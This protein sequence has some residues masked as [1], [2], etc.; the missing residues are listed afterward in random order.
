MT[1]NYSY[2]TDPGQEF[3]LEQAREQVTREQRYFERLSQDPQFMNTLAGYANTFPT[4]SA[5]VS[6]A[7]SQ[8]GVPASDP[9]AA[10]LINAELQTRDTLGPVDK[11]GGG[12]W[13]AVAGTWD[14]AVDNNVKGAVRWGF[15]AWDAA[16][17]MLAGGAP[18][19]A[20][21]VAQ[22]ENI[23]YGEAWKQQDPYFFEAVGSL[24]TPGE[25]VNLGSGWMPNSDVAPDVQQNVNQGMEQLERDTRDLPANERMVKRLEGS[26]GIWTNAV[27]DSLE[28][29]AM[30]KPLTHMNY[31]ETD[32]VIFNIDSWAG[33][34]VQ[35]PWSPGRFLASNIVEP[36]TEPW[37]KI[38][39]TGDFLSQIFLDPVDWV[40][41]GLAKAGAS[42]RR[43]WG[44]SKK[45]A[46]EVLAVSDEVVDVARAGQ[47]A[48]PAPRQVAREALPSG[49]GPKSL[50]SGTDV[51]VPPV[52]SKSPWWLSPVESLKR[53]A[54]WADPPEW[55][56][57]AQRATR[58]GAAVGDEGLKFK[59]TVNGVYST[60]LP[61]LPGRAPQKLSVIRRGT[62][63]E[64][65]WEVL[66]PDGSRV[67]LLPDDPRFSTPQ[68]KFKTLN[69]A[70]EASLDYAKRYAD[71]DM[72]V[73]GMTAQEFIESGEDFYVDDYQ[74]VAFG[75]ASKEEETVQK[76]AHR[77]GTN[78][79]A[80]ASGPNGQNAKVRVFG[81]SIDLSSGVL[82]PNAPEGLKAALRKD[83]KLRGENLQ[84]FGDPNVEA[85][86]ATLKW[87]S[88]NGYGKIKWDEDTVIMNNEFIGGPDSF[89]PGARIHYEVPDEPMYR[90]DYGIDTID[91]PTPN[92]VQSVYDFAATSG[93]GAVGGAASKIDETVA[94]LDELQATYSKESLEP[95]Y[96]S[97]PK[98]DAFNEA[99]KALKAQKS[100]A[101]SSYIA[102]SRKAGKPV[103]SRYLGSPEKWAE[104]G[105]DELI[106][107]YHATDPETAAR[108]RSE[109]LKADTKKVTPEE[110]QRY[111]AGETA[112]GLYV[113]SDP[114]VGGMYGGAD[115]EIVKITIRKGDLSVP[116]EMSKQGVGAGTSVSNQVHKGL[117]TPRFGAVIKGD[118][119]ATASR[120]A[121]DLTEGVGKV[122]GEG[123]EMPSQYG[124]VPTE[125]AG[126]YDEA[127]RAMAERIKEV[128]IEQAPPSARRGNARP[129]FDADF[130][131]RGKKVEMLVD[132]LEA[133]TKLA[134]GDD[135]SMRYM[136]KLL[137]FLYRDGIT[138]PNQ[139]RKRLFE[140]KSREEIK[141]VLAE[142]LVKEGGQEITLPGG[143]QYGKLAS[144]GLQAPAQ[145]VAPRGVGVV[146]DVQRNITR[147]FSKSIS[148]RNVN[149]VEDPSA[150]YRLFDDTLRH[151]NL[152]RGDM[153]KSLDS[154]GNEIEL[155]VDAVFDRLLN[156]EAGDKAEAFAIMGDFSGV[157]FAKLV[158]DGVDP[159]LA[160]RATRWWADNGDK[161]LFD[162]ERMGR[163]DLGSSPYDMTKIGDDLIGGVGTQLTADLWT[164]QI[165][166][167]DAR[168]IKRFA[169]ESDMLGRISNRAAWRWELSEVDGVKK[170]DVHERSVIRA[171]DALMTKVWKPFVL[172]RGAW[173]LRIL[174]DDQFRLAAEGYGILNHP[175]RIL[176]YAITRPDDWKSAFKAGTVDVFG[177]P[178]NIKNMDDMV[179]GNIFRESLMSSASPQ[180][181][182]GAYGSTQHIPIARGA[183][184]YDEGLT[185]QLQR[186][187]GSPLTSRL[188]SSGS[189]KPVDETVKWLQGLG[190]EGTREAAE[191]ELRN[192]AELHKG[193]GDIPQKILDKDQATLTNVVSR[194][195]AMLHHQ[196]GGEVYLDNGT[197]QMFGWRD[198]KG[199]SLGP[200]DYRGEP[201][202]VVKDRA[203]DDLLSI[204]SGK[205]KVGETYIG[206]LSTRESMEAAQKL[207]RRKVRANDN[208][209]PTAVRV[210]TQEIVDPKGSETML[211]QLDGAVRGMFDW[212]M[213]RPSDQ[214]SR[215][216]EFN[217]A[218]WDKISDLYPYMDDALRKEIDQLAGTNPRAQEGLSR[219]R[220]D[221]RGTEIQGQL[222]SM[223]QADFHA[224]AYGL[225]MV[226]RTLF[227]LTEKRNISDSLRIVFPFVEA[228]GEFIGRWG[229]LMVTGD[230]NVKNL[231]RLR[232]T[233]GGARRSGFFQ[234]NE[235]GQEVF[236]YPA[237]I[238]K[239][240]VGL[241]NTLNN[242]PGASAVMGGDVSQEVAG[243]IRATGNVESLNFASGMIP[244]FGPVFQAAARALPQNPDY[245]WVRDI[246]APFG[247]EGNIGVSFA[248]AWIKRFVSAQGGNDDPVLTYT[249]NSTV[250]DVI[251]TKIDRGDFQ[252]VTNEAEV[253][254]LV[255][256][257]EEEAKGL[258]MVR[259]AATWWNP[260]SP[261]YKF[262]KEDKDGLI[263]S[264]N[265]LAGEYYKMKEEADGDD[266][267]AFD[268]FFARFGFLPQ[269]FK[270]GKTYSIQDRSRDESGSRFERSQPKLFEDYPSIAMYLD[271]NIGVESEYDFSTTI[272]QLEQGLRESWTGEQ[273]IYVQQ[274]QLGDLWWE[275]IES[276][277]ELIPD[278]SMK[279]AFKT[280]M[281]AQVS[282]AYPFW[283]KP[284]PG[285]KQAVTNEQQR[286]QL[287]VALEDGTLD[288]RVLDAVRVYE[289]YRE[290]VLEQVRRTGASTIDGPKSQ[291]TDSGIVATKGRD[292]LRR[293]AEDLAVEYPEFTPL[294]ENIYQWEVA[295]Y[296]DTPKPPVI[297]AYGEG[298]IFDE[299][300]MAEANGSG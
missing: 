3:L 238:T 105:A 25:E 107:V 183:A 22:Q 206:D 177:T 236:N 195:N 99:S 11:P 254:A 226:E 244:G 232:Q 256:E 268:A 237:F 36:G 93:R 246:V 261:S 114:K 181:G 274:D 294:F 282:E 5:E 152:K 208:R 175:A 64:K 209:F 58:Q 218:Y 184:R 185:F 135:A 295:T 148:G 81:R 126:V 27:S 239:A 21:E 286:D 115:R 154:N 85:W 252:G 262:Q 140:A 204:A 255:R 163:V 191:R 292:W 24:F 136:D 169:N 69:E 109:G 116:R 151:F 221:K 207:V 253:N 63:K 104:V 15:A 35:T 145:R 260:A 129:D 2:F 233:V 194:Q 43:V 79:P 198:P 31:A 173:T 247:T 278:K 54:T 277:A 77:G 189:E 14:E 186:F 166:P 1:T 276:Q 164:G 203:D 127:A 4:A 171:A 229:R 288:Y 284:V 251:R 65:Y 50:Q 28:Q 120:K 8:G 20:K 123:F 39:G 40:G 47:P 132:R 100:E 234:E 205:K 211:Q 289:S 67:S 213:T 110:L 160:R 41:G 96:F 297:D 161:A 167:V 231:N 162:A 200:S 71:E 170:F 156:L 57:N 32:S 150:A 91:G 223:E 270:G 222:T 249:Y 279:D 111:E 197:G 257:A 263:W 51:P 144:A 89:D 42:G 248:P 102:E 141:S 112:P 142:W 19:R 73:Q 240:Q 74:R 168:T 124:G 103:D 193:M 235:Y 259:A 18:L 26:P 153:V 133:T 130:E 199:G 139:V 88:D 157:T 84:G 30:G 138:L 9:L 53:V 33:Q 121:A 210:P 56:I 62:G 17:Q 59:R 241:H 52:D 80:V 224:K 176:N 242:L 280:T 216:P 267:A 134:L 215:V 188:A 119:P 165:K 44:V 16:Y 293:K 214:F 38:S 117:V 290:E 92:E 66:K 143:I 55:F 137:S 291:T 83:S 269:A 10:Q 212:L 90:Y 271:P 283:N 118:I 299:Y 190:P 72:R 250:T 272:R 29:S 60:E 245:D 285:K 106:T 76:L 86:D 296:N 45:V 178:M 155:S 243:N 298:D 264:Y 46:D 300:E 12:I 101:V 131:L 87:M 273:F 61:S 68:A 225:T 122:G 179:N 228:W 7:L 230:R 265:N 202:W 287:M 97:S 48:L 275:N 158:D 258:L 13:D 196:L 159:E 201:K 147:R 113:S 187:R 174:M 75:G 95:G 180:F 49:S 220:K 192:Q 98:A 34:Q 149:M 281:R 128:D 70:K 94:L 266:A 78:R 217:R 23:S 227:T 125:G 37:K 172:L 219:A 182:A 146:S 6:L 82:P 108:I